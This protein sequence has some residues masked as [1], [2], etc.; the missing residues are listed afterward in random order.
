MSNDGSSLHSHAVATYEKN[1][2]SGFATSQLSY[3]QALAHLEVLAQAPSQTFLI[4]DALDECE[5][6][7][8]TRLV[9]DLQALLRRCDHPIRIFISSRPNQDIKAELHKGLNRTIEATDN[10]HDICRYVDDTI[11]KPDSPAFWRTKVPSD[12]RQRVFEILTKNAEGKYV[13][14]NSHHHQ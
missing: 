7:T 3:E 13:S 8:R 11:T 10:R 9:Q 2:A 6:S 14:S 12:L 4:L 5:E 1:K